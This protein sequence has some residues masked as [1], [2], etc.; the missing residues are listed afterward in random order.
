MELLRRTTT[1][2]YL[3]AATMRN[4]GFSIASSYLYL[5]LI[6]VGPGPTTAA[7]SFAGNLSSLDGALTRMRGQQHLSSIDRGGSAATHNHHHTREPAP[8]DDDGERL[9][10]QNDDDDDDDERLL[11]CPYKA[12]D[13]YDH[14]RPD[15]P[16]NF[17]AGGDR[18]T[19]S[20]PQFQ[21]EPCP[22]C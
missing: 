8:C 7:A 9:Q 3:Q 10:R 5:A 14:P 4:P 11:P 17:K 16:P 18:E 12:S 15:A 1:S 13:A 22:Q 6:I 19:D 20:G 21:T 2:L